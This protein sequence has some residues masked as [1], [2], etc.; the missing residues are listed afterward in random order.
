[1]AELDVIV[2]GGGHAGIE[3]ALAAVRLGASTCLVTFT[4][5]GIGRMSCNPAIGGVAKGQIVREIDALGGAMGR[6]IDEA[7]IQFRMLNTSK[8]AAVISPRAQADK[9]AYQRAAQQMCEATAGLT[10]VEGEAVQLL[11]QGGRQQAAGGGEGTAVTAACRLTSAASVAGVQLA[12]GRAL[13]AP[14]VVLTTGTFLGGLLHYGEDR[15]EGGRAGEKASHGLGD[16]LRALGFR[17]GRLKTG[18]PPRL[19]ASTIDWSAADE[20]K[21]DDPPVPFSFMTREITKPQVSCYITYTNANTHK[22]IADNLARSP[23]YSGQIVGVGPRYCPSIEDKIKRFPD[24]ESHHI[25]LEPEGLDSGEVYPNGISTSMPRDVQD[26][27]VRTIP[28]LERARIVR[29]GYAVEYDFIPPTQVDATL[30]TK[31]VRGLYLA[32]Q[33]NGTTG[34]EEAGAQG[35]MAGLNAALTLGGREPVVLRRDQAYIGVLIDDLTTRGT[36]EPY[37]MFTSLAEYRLRLRTDNADRRLTPLGI[38]LG[39]VEQERRQRFEAKLADYKRG[40]AL[41][42][43]TMQGDKTLYFRL[44]SPEFPWS[45][46]LELAPGLATLDPAALATLEIDARYDG[47]M[48]REDA[49]VARMRELETFRLPPGLHYAAI[50]PLRKEAREKLARVGPLTLGQAARIP[51]IGPGDLTVLRVWLKSS[52]GSAAAQ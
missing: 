33:I 23:L 27:L 6:L 31:L 43:E 24:R 37:R 15:I 30:Q 45:K 40:E 1:M 36:D 8:G 22:V 2:V 16:Q 42:R 49:E 52:R 34:Y 41:L 38:E 21:G 19:D 20:Q 25:F 50:Q 7:G 18:T 14:R 39:C 48:G 47:Y 10:I 51:G 46:V 26:A 28:G 13:H 12:D 32:G 29:Y 5:D 3:A 35:L 17:T 4:R 9:D 44:R 11:L